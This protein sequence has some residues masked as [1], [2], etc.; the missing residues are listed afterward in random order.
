MSFLLPEVGTSTTR[1]I[2]SDTQDLT[3]VTPKFKVELVHDRPTG[4]FSVNGRNSGQII[5]YLTL[6]NM[7]EP[8][9]PL[10]RKF[11]SVL[12]Y[13]VYSNRTTDRV[14]LTI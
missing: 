5:G 8:P 12:H 10:W 13:Y 4:T 14:S 6:I 11:T 1:T 3:L 2:N 7:K 9:L